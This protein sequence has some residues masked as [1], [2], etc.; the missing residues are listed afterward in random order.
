VRE[1]VVALAELEPVA[2]GTLA[3]GIWAQFCSM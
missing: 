3:G 2:F 1:R